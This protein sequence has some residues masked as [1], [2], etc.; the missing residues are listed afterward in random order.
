M[1]RRSRNRDFPIAK[2]DIAKHPD[3]YMLIDGYFSALDYKTDCKHFVL[4]LMKRKHQ[5][6][7]L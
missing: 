6:V 5:K 3:V 4:K 2:S 7:R 1:S